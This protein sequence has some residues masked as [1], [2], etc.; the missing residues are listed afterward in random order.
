MEIALSEDFWERSKEGG[1][2]EVK[3]SET[4][5]IRLAASC[6]R[7]DNSNQAENAFDD[8]VL[9]KDVSEANG[10]GVAVD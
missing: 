4:F 7:R 3:Q 9:K 2:D 10:K 8:K 6:A 5:D 1:S